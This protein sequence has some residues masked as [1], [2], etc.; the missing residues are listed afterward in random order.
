L[1]LKSKY[2]IL[3][4]ALSCTLFLQHEDKEKTK[5]KAINVFIHLKI[6]LIENNLIFSKVFL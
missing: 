3:K 5:N 2:V 6:S 4:L 1:P